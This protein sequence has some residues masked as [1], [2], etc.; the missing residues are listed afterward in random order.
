MPLA[1]DAT[2]RVIVILRDQ[3]LSTLDARSTHAVRAAAVRTDQ[4]GILA[5]LA[6]V[7]APRV[8]TFHLINVVA[9]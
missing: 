9:P 4:R 8:T 5:E 6:R 1:H 7:H 3:H 2:Q